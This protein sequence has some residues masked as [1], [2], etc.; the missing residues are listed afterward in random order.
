VRHGIIAAVLLGLDPR[1]P[2]NVWQTQ[3][4]FVGQRW[5]FG[6]RDACCYLSQSRLSQS[7]L[8]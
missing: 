5:A 7:R 3:R 6:V 2:G 4:C 8:I 1:H